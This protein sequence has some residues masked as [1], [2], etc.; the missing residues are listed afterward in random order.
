M[1]SYTIG[2]TKRSAHRKSLAANTEDTVTIDAAA[3]G[4]YWR[5]VEVYV[6]G[7]SAD[8]VF[9]TADGTAATVDGDNTYICPPGSFTT[10]PQPA[11]GAGTVRLISGGACTYS[12]T[13][14]HA[15]PDND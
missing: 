1:A 15:D 9:V 13:V 8:D 11:S 3:A 4:G 14:T 2:A 5:D 10:V 7:T 12:V 6:K